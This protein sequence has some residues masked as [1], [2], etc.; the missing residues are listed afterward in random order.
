MSP[1]FRGGE[2]DIPEI[3]LTTEVTHLIAETSSGEYVSI[4][5]HRSTRMNA[6]IICDAALTVTF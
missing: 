1:I 5:T 3:H 6:G 2:L 4:V